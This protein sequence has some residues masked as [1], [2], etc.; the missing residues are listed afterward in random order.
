VK[1]KTDFVTNSSSNSYIVMLP[2]GF[3]LHDHLSMLEKGG[4]FNQFDWYVGEGGL[5]EIKVEKLENFF[6]ILIEQG[7]IL[8]DWWEDS[9]FYMW[10][11]LDIC[12]E[13]KLVIT[14]YDIP[15]EGRNQIINVGTSK[16]LDRVKEIGGLVEGKAGLCNQ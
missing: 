10:I 9:K 16:I 12:Q 13:L 3:E 1:V 15:H 7:S 14:E 11:V 5:S 2:P 4:V 6:N 8:E